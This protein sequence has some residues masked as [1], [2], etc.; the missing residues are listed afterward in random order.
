MKKEVIKKVKVQ[1]KCNEYIRLRDA[2]KPCI[3][4]GK[5]TTLQAGHYWPVGGYDGLRFD[6]L[7]INGECAYCN[8]WDKAHLIGYRKNLIKRIGLESVEALDAK[9]EDYR[10]NGYKFTRSELLEIYNYYCEKIKQLKSE[11]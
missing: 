6:E 7:N 11:L 3:S 2:G 4:C 8:A 10:R 1:E 9:A 5:V